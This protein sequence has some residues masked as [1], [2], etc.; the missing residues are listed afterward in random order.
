MEPPVT[1]I[2]VGPRIELYG[3]MPII[4]FDVLAK[5]IEA[6]YPHAMCTGG[7]AYTGLL[8]TIQLGARRG[9]EHRLEISPCQQ[10]HETSGPN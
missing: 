2:N 4:I 3:P 1:T 8:M 6:D 9:N 10:Q 7:N 5:C